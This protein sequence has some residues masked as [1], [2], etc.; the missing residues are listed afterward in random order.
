MRVAGVDGAKGGWI[1]VLRD[2][3]SRKSPEVFIFSSFSEI[4]AVSDAP[5]IVAV[6]MPI[7][8]PD[9][10]GPRGRGPERA[11]RPLLEKRQSS[12]FSMPSRAAVY[13]EDYWEA[14]RVALETSD[15]PRKISKQAFQLFPKIREIDQ[16]MS[17]EMEAR[18]FEVHPEVAFWRLNG[19]THMSLPKKVKS[20]GNGP[21]LDER[22]DLLIEYGFE[23]EFLDQKPPR[24]AARDDLLDA[25]VSSVIAERIAKGVAKPFPLDFSR[26]GKGLRMAIWA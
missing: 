9:R 3:E 6:D 21:G 19:E 2:I 10:S 4:I 26:D 16:L 13:C 14:C 12:V 11:V 23:R 1:A 22:R 20:R 18:I 8:L 17:V 24:G 7:G 5:V 25:C 15:P